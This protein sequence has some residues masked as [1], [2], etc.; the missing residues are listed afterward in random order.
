MFDL[1]KVDGFK[2]L[3]AILALLIIMKPASITIKIVLAKYSG[4]I[5]EEKEGVPNTG[6]LIGELERFI[7]LL[8]LTQGQY[9]AIGFVLTAKSIARYKKI[10]E[11]IEFSEYY[12]LGTFLSTLIAI[13]TYLIIFSSFFS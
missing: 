11:K 8:M 2:I 12:L 13:I 9:A 6:A 7:I 1:F 5:K 4:F 3:S 10:V